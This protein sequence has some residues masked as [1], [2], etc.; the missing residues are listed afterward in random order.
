MSYDLEEKSRFEARPVECYLFE[1][2]TSRWAYTSAE[3]AIQIPG[4]EDPFEPAPILAER[5]E[6]GSEDTAG[7]I[8][9]TVP[10]TLPCIGDFVAYAPAG[11]LSLTLI[12]VHRTSL[13]EYKTPFRGSVVGVEWEDSLARLTCQPITHEFGRLIPRLGYQRQC[14]WPLYSA[15]C[16]INA[17]SFAQSAV[18]TS[19]AG[20]VIAAD[21]F[22]DCYEDGWFNAGFV[23]WG[24]Q[25]RFIVSHVGNA[26]TLMSPFQ[27]LEV[28]LTVVAYPGCDQTEAMC[29]QKFG[30]LDH[31]L[32]FARVPY[33]N[34]H[35]RR[36][37]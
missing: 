34:P 23:L 15:G 36:A 30:N 7:G 35:T 28:G 32:G 33:R 18:V 12:Q 6:H 5:Q 2:G 17:A 1:L 20:S 4:W 3:E 31:H 26:I 21:E 27:G 22:R 13:G 24:S 8:T 25:R 19:V 10:R 16:G 9:L 14:N 11:R 37:F 29:A